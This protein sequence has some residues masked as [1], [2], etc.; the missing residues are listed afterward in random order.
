MAFNRVA[1]RASATRW[2]QEPQPPDGTKS[3]SH[4]MVLR[5]FNP[6]AEALEATGF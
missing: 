5:G 1:S 6:V 4:P 2:H 3:L